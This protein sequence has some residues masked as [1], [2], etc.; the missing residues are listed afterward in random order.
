MGGAMGSDELWESVA[1][2]WLQPAAAAGEASD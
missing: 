1:P 2:Y